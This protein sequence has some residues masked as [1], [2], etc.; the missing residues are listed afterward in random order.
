MPPGL[1][2]GRYARATRKKSPTL[3]DRV[4]TFSPREEVE[5]RRAQ[6][7]PRN[8]ELGASES[9]SF[10]SIASLRAKT[11]AGRRRL[12]ISLYFEQMAD[13]RTLPS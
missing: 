10:R 12:E 1:F 7:A 3:E 6:R 5:P 8:V 11:G 9:G 4:P 2:S 13:A